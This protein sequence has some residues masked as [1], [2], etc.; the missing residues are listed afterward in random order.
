MVNGL[1]PREVF[2]CQLE[3]IT[4]NSGVGRTG[5]P[6]AGAP[7]TGKHTNENGYRLRA[8][9][10]PYLRYNGD[11]PPSMNTGIGFS[12]PWDHSKTVTPSNIR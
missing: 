10:S 7:S 11:G 2:C 8:F 5:A 12:P 6:G 1:I 4:R 9:R 3:T